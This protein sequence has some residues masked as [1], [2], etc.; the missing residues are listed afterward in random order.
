MEKHGFKNV[1]GVCCGDGPSVG[2]EMVND[3]R[4]PLV[5][6]T[7]STH[8]GRMIAEKVNSRFG[9][10]I[11]ELGGNNANIVMPDADLE[12]AF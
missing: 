2:N 1:L 5:S 11:L 10:A 8:V 9:R 4:V 12:L 7:G 6:F 3:P